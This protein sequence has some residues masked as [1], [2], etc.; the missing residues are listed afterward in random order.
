[1]I[2]IKYRTKICV[3]NDIDMCIWVKSRNCGCLVTW[4]CYQLIAKPGNKTALV[5]WPD[6]YVHVCNTWGVVSEDGLY[7]VARSLPRSL[8]NSLTRSMNSWCNS[9]S[10]IPIAN[11]SINVLISPNWFQ[12]LFGNQLIKCSQSLFSHSTT[13]AR[14]QMSDCWI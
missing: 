11:C 12:L 9:T 3:R 7:G 5:S 8:T 1:M 10:S 6:P 2:S 14:V 4:F 13:T